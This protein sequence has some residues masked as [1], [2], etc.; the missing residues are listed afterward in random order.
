MTPRIAHPAARDAPEEQAIGLLVR[1]LLPGLEPVLT[2]PIVLELLG[3]GKAIGYLPPRIRARNHKPD[4][5]LIFPPAPRR[6]GTVSRAQW[7]GHS[8]I[9]AR[10]IAAEKAVLG[11]RNLGAV[12]L[13]QALHLA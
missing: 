9:D 13:F 3:I 4:E 7:Q 1:A 10:K 2:D 5:L 12:G 6:C 8:Q 11:P